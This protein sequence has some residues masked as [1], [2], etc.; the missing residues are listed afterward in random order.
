MKRLVWL[1]VAVFCAT[2][3]LGQ[4]FD[5]LNPQAKDCPCCHPGAC[6]MPGCCSLPGSC[7]MAFDS[8]PLAQGANQPAP[9]RKR[10]MVENFFASFGAPT[11]IRGL[12]PVLA[13]RAVPA[14]RAPLFTAHCSFLI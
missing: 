14:V 7:S 3:A 2:L 8:A 10:E 11:A 12:R 6:G 1:V 9:A 4:V 5:G 13:L